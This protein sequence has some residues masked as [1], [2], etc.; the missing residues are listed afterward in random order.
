MNILNNIWIAISTPNEALVKFCC[1]LFLFV[2]APLSFSLIN[3]VFDVSSTKN[4]KLIYILVTALVATISTLFLKSPINLILNY[5]CSFC[6]LRFIFKTGK[7]KALIAALFPSV[8]FN[9]IGNLLLN[10]YLTLLDITYEEANT[11]IIYRIPF[12]FLMYSTVVLL[13]III[14][15]QKITITLSDNLNKKDKTYNNFKY[16]F[17]FFVHINSNILPYELY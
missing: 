2:E 10:P 15:H 3:N 4:K 14:K 8:V 17:W 12:S 1:I 13:N 5:I 6:I 11:I 16:Y 9:L 7:I